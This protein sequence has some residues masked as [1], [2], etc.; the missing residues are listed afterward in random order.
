MG[1]SEAGDSASVQF[2]QAPGLIW[3][4]VKMPFLLMP[5]EVLLGGCGFYC[6]MDED[7]SSWGPG[8]TPALSSSCLRNMRIHPQAGACVST[9]HCSL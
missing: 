9:D 2:Q 5:A 3:H 1:Y 7:G 4:H 6:Q 8:E